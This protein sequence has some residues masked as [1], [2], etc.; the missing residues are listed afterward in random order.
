[1]F[2]VHCMQTYIFSDEL[3]VLHEDQCGQAVAPRESVNIYNR[4]VY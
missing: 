2:L 1:M 3:T 4:L